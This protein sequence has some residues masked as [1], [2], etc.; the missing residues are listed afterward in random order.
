VTANKD[1][2]DD[3]IHVT[4]DADC[5][6]RSCEQLNPSFPFPWVLGGCEKG[7]LDRWLGSGRG[8]LY[9][10]DC[11]GRTSGFLVDCPAWEFLTFWG[12]GGVGFVLGVVDRDSGKMLFVDGGFEMV[13]LQLRFNCFVR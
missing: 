1:G 4:D 8:L 3:D 5:T 10:F 13:A 6:T 9:L 12:F 11:E 2:H 7:V